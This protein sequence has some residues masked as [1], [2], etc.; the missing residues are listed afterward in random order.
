MDAKN[1]LEKIDEL[2]KLY[3]SSSNRKVLTQ[4]RGAVTYTLRQN[5]LL[6]VRVEEIFE[7]NRLSMSV[8]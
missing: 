1:S 7:T 5:A 2:V 8:L 6:R 4:L 3:V